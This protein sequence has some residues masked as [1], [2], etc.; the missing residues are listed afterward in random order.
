MT[1]PRAS[2]Q[3][4]EMD[5]R[6]SSMKL[7]ISDGWICLVPETVLRSSCRRLQISRLSHLSSMMPLT[8]SVLLELKAHISEWLC[9]ASMLLTPVF[10]STY[11]RVA[12]SSLFNAL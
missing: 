4:T 10:N 11:V 12:H 6:W 1:E 8:T 7:P 3:P 9:G 2:D 5:S